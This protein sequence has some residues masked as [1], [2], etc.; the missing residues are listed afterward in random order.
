MKFNLFPGENEKKIFQLITFFCFGV[1]IGLSPTIDQ[2]TMAGII[3]TLA[4]AFFGA[5]FAY[6]FNSDREENKKDEVDL[7]SANKAI[8]TVIRIFNYVHSYNNQ[9]IKSEKGNPGFYIS[10]RPSLSGSDK[11][12]KI[13]YDSISFLIAKSKPEILIDLV[14][15]EELFDN[16]KKIL[17]TRNRMHLEEVHPLMEKA[18]I[19]DGAEVSML[20]ID[21]ILGDRLSTMMKRIT[22]SLIEETEYLESKSEEVVRELYNVMKD[23]FKGGN[24]I[25]MK[26]INKSSNPDG[27]KAA[28]D[29]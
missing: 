11:D 19:T 24:V 7:A 8:F 3:A 17:A 6:K 23:L 27:D 16:F 26:K 9:F 2:K 21:N 28:A 4:A 12:W 13:D 5:F 1:G 29:S 25:Q 18:G 22:V 10:I 20:D 15:L 14:E